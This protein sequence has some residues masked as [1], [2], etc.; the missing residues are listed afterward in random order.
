MLGSTPVK[1][2]PVIM[3]KLLKK[4][5]ER[6]SELPDDEQDAGAS[7][8]LEE[9]EDK[10]RW[11]ATFAKSQGALVRLANEARAEIARGD[12]LPV[13]PATKPQ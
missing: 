6:V 8:I 4:A 11:R 5:F 7:I 12:V 2:Y 9:I 3:T 13:D 10:D 1:C